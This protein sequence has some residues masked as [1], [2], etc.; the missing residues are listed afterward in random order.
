MCRPCNHTQIYYGK[1]YAALQRLDSVRLA[2]LTYARK[3]RSKRM[4][5]RAAVRRRAER[6][7]KIVM[8]HSLA[9]TEPE[10]IL[11]GRA[12]EVSVVL[13]AELGDEDDHE[14]IEMESRDVGLRADLQILVICPEGDVLKAKLPHRSE[15]PRALV[16]VLEGLAMWQGGPARGCTF[17]GRQGAGLHRL[18]FPSADLGGRRSPLVDFS[19]RMHGHA[20]GRI[21]G[22][23]DFRQLRLPGGDL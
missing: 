22:V 21:H 4:H 13:V 20:R 2:R 18:G 12:V 10:P 15:H 6:K 7:A 14:F 23:G 17:C 16:T 11:G 8:D 19:T 9:T 5:A 3:M 1:V